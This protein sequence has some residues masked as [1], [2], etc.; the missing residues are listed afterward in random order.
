MSSNT[1]RLRR[2]SHVRLVDQVRQSLEEAILAGQVQPGEH[3]AETRIGEQL[4]V[5]RTTVREALLMLEQQGLVVSVPRRG[6]FVTRLSEQDALDLA[7]LR[8]L[9]EGFAVV[10]SRSR[11]DDN[12]IAQLKSHIEDMLACDIP[13]EL[14]RLIEIE[15]GRELVHQCRLIAGQVAVDGLA[16]LIVI[17]D[18]QPVIGGNGE[19]EQKHA[20][21]YCRRRH[22]E[23]QPYPGVPVPGFLLSRFV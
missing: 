3:L 16:P 22:G 23:Q 10:V 11:I 13:G 15:A 19:I 2:P 5:S 8:V 9:L 14:P 12:L 18:D 6:M 21:D 1:M 4:H 17:V 7:F 20:D